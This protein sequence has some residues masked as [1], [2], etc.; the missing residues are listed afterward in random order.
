MNT[1][2]NFRDISAMLKT[3][4]NYKPSCG[5]KS[6]KVPTKN[7]RIMSHVKRIREKVMGTQPML[8]HTQPDRSN[9]R[10]CILDI[11]GSM[12][13]IKWLINFLQE[14]MLQPH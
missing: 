6:D 8:T 2:I 10:D 11:R 7:V 9:M 14:R 3:V 4:M 1:G 12:A 5:V 13:E